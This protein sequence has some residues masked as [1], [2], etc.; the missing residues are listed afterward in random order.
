VSA[1]ADV[2][3]LGPQQ[4]W[5]GIVARTVHGDSVSFSYLEL[6]AGAI[7]PEHAHEN[8]QVGILL[9]GSVTFTIGDETRELQSGATWCIRGHVPHSVVVGPDG[10]VIVEVFSP[11]RDDWHAIEHQQP[12]PARWPAP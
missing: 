4:I 7:V 9:D 5:D 8:E 11:V 3:S 6:E 1:F 12:R 10:A 2:G